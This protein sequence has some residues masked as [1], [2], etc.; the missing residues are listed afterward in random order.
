MSYKTFTQVAIVVSIVLAF[1]AV[2][3]SVIASGTCGGTY[4]VEQD[5][6][7]DTLAAACGT[8]ASA[9]YAANPG[10]GANLYVGQVLTIPDG[11]YNTYSGYN[12]NYNGY[13]N[14]YNGYNNNYNGYQGNP[15]HYNYG[16]GGVNGTTYVVQYGDTFSEIASRYGVSM[17]A[18]WSANPS[19]ENIDLLYPGQVLNIPPSS[20]ATPAPTW[21]SYGPPSYSPPYGPYPY[22]SWYAATPTPT[23]V[24]T[25]LSYGT[26]SA[27][28][29][30]ANIELSNKAN[31]QVYVSLQGTARDGTNVI[32]EYPVSGTIDKTI[33]AGFYYYVAWVAGREFSGALNLPGGSSHSITFHLNE[34]DAQ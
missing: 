23:Q 28:A 1:S 21:P 34:V 2:P 22:P 33:P 25:P 12:N 20:W 31:A 19:I 11:G 13:N 26:V 8:T 9:L 7:I 32:R 6:T 15:S 24:P 29:P 3:A 30:M 5:E 27:G 17:Y 14:T 4:I 18:L 16:Q 10:I